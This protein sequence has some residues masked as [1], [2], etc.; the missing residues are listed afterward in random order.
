M[1]GST[2]GVHTAMKILIAPDSFKGSLAAADVAGAIERGVRRVLP[3]AEIECIPL[4]DGGEGTVGAL[5]AATGGQIVYE[6]VTGP[7]GEPVDAFF[8]ILGD[9]TTAVIEMAAAS[10][11]PL[12]PPGRRDPLRTTTRGTGELI[13][14]ALERGCQKI[15]VGIGGSATNDGGAGMAQA[16][17]VSFRDSNGREIGPGGGELIRIHA[18]DVSGLDSRIAGTRVVVACDVDNPLVGPKGASAVYGPQKGATPEQVEALDRGLAHFA[19][20]IERSLGIGVADLPGAG[21]AGGLGGGLVAFAG[22]SLEPGIGIVLDAVNFHTRV[23]G[24]DLVV[25]GEGAIDHQ[26]AYGKVPVGVARVAKKARVPVVAVGGS[27]SQ[28]ARDLYR[29]GIDAVFSCTMRPMSFE[30]AFG[31]TPTALEFLGEQIVRTLLL[32]RREVAR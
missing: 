19:N 26:T 9:G 24:A 22:A 4:A 32:G 21:A 2:L 13:R 18:L 8:G 14:L 27:V 31:Q 7:L 23:Q 17:G 15:I 12:V 10:G 20:V 30:D 5:V 1:L 25:T 29:E 28:S 11:L 16:L 6:R 3:H